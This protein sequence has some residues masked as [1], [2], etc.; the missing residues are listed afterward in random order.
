MVHCWSLLCRYLS[1]LANSSSCI[2]SDLIFNAHL[3][4]YAMWESLICPYE[5]GTLWSIAVGFYLAGRALYDS[6]SFM[7]QIW[8]ILRIVSKLHW[9]VELLIWWF[10]LQSLSI[11]WCLCLSFNCLLTRYELKN[12]S[13][14][15]LWRDF[16]LDIHLLKMCTEKW[17][18]S[19][20]ELW[21]EQFSLI[22]NSV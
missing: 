19:N 1:I 22:G 21:C 10:G 14:M 9:S 18:W 11:C 17:D 2:Y 5:A 8:Q 3:L 15:F 16:D 13:E 20:P 12:R 6:P 7:C 4:I